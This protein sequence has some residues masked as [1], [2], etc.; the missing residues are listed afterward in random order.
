MKESGPLRAKAAR[1][2]Q[3]LKRRWTTGGRV[4]V[5]FLTL[6]P[7]FLGNATPGCFFLVL[8][9]V[10][11]DHASVALGVLNQFLLL[12]LIMFAFSFF[13][14]VLGLQIII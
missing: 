10:Y 4:S 12:L 8:K 2:S 3:I 9:K 5:Q 11:L 14:A 6:W 7:W 1:K 13:R